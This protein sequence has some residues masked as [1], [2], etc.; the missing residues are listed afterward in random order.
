METIR[1]FIAVPLPER[2]LAELGKL[3]NHMKSLNRDVK[4][5][6][7]DAIH[8][9]LKFLGNLSEVQLTRVFAG[10]DQLF[11]KPH[12]A[13]SLVAAGMGA[14]PNNR[15]P[16]VLWVGV[17]GSGVP[18]LLN[19]QKK[20]E[21]VLAKQGFSEEKRN[22]SPHLTVARINLAGHLERLMD[23]FTNYTFPPQ[24]ITVKEVLVMKSELKPSG[25]IYSIQKSYNLNTI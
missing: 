20:I 23:E 4:W 1:T 24:E 11:Q 3:I 19:L 5:V 10:M 9:T 2:I 7:P 15:R 21:T 18:E 17:E 6:R 13:F 25:A 8:L 16:R 22:F 12:G 14:F